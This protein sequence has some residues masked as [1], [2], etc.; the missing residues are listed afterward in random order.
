VGALR[1]AQHGL[2]VLLVEVIEH[3]RRGNNTSLSTAMIPGAGTR[4]QREAGVGDSPDGRLPALGL[5]DL[6]ADHV[7]GADGPT[8]RAP[9]HTTE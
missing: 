5:A 6:A 1:A 8:A 3:Y 7:D 9:H 4:L 2:D